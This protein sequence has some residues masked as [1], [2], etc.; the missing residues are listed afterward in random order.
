MK[1]IE[2]KKE[3]EFDQTIAE[4]SA[5]NTLVPVTANI[6]SNGK[7]WCSACEVGIPFILEKIENSYPGSILV[8]IRVEPNDSI[9]K[10]LQQHSKVKLKYVPGLFKVSDSPE[11]TDL[12]WE[13][14]FSTTEL[15]SIFPDAEE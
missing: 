7:S 10:F 9:Y 5:E 8:K 15:D 4:K 3:K 2:I 6:D 1:A 12:L 13:P 11:W 14:F